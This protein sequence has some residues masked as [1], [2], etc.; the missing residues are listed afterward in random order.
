MFVALV[1]IY[2]IIQ[3]NTSNNDQVVSCERENNCCRSN[4]DCQYVWYTGGCNTPEYV[5]IRQK[6]AREAGVKLGEAPRRENITC[7]CEMNRCVDNN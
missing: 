4:V 7:T 6:E 3:N 2:L 1:A 5:A